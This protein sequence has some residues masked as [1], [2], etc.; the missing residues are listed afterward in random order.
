MNLK[1]RAAGEVATVFTLSY[2]VISFLNYI[3]PVA[4]IVVTVTG[5]SLY[6]IY[7]AYQIRLTQLRLE[8]NKE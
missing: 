2:A 7:M 5:L 4:A 6:W 1:F 3:S 8:Q